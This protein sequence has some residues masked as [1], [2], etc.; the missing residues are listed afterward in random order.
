MY[1]SKTVEACIGGLIDGRGNWNAGL[2]Q[3]TIFSWTTKEFLHLVRNVV[4]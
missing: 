2:M 3:S 1:L 4:G